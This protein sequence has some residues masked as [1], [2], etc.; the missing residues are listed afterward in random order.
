MTSSRITLYLPETFLHPISLFPERR[1]S[2]KLVLIKQ[3]TQSPNFLYFF[4]L[5]I[6]C[7]QGLEGGREEGENL[8]WTPREV[9]N[10]TQGSISQP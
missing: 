3:R 8:K 10:P 1:K 7:Q 2:L 9:W 4:F 5:K 6:Y